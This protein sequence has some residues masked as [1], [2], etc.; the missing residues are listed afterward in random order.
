[1]RSC[2]APGALDMTLPR[3]VVA[4]Q[5]TDP[6][7]RIQ[8]R[9]Q[10]VPGIAESGWDARLRLRFE[11]RGA[12]TVLAANAHAGPLC[13]QKALYPE[14]PE[15]CHAIV[16]H[17]PGGIVGGDRLA[18]DIEAGEGAHTPFTLPGAAQLYSP[19]RRIAA[20]DARI[21]LAVHAHRKC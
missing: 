19:D 11:R 17:P 5:D 16:L 4:A 10:P 20:P 21:R 3:A 12:R 14:D 18:V 9:P 2:V 6:Q 13:V 8:S 1:M 7:S 15:V